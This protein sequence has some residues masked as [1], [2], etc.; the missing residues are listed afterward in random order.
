MPKS[1]N[2]STICQML[3]RTLILLIILFAFGLRLYN[4][5]YHSLWFDEAVSVY[6]AKQDVSRIIEVGFTLD[7]DRLPPLYYLTL[8]SWTF[9]FGWHEFTVR[10]LSVFIGTLLVPVVMRLTR[11]LF[12]QP[13]ALISGLLVALN[14]F[15]IWYSQE[16]RMYAPAVLFGTWAVLSWLNMVNSHIF[17]TPISQRNRG[18]RSRRTLILHSSFFIFFSILALYSHLYAGFLLPALGLWLLI[19]Y[20]RHLKLIALFSLAGFIITLAYSPILLAIW[21]FSAEATPG[22]PLSGLLERAWWL[23]HAFTVWQ[24]PLSSRL[25]ML[26]PAGVALFALMSLAWQTPPQFSARGKAVKLAESLPPPNLPL[27]EE[28]VASLAGRTEGDRDSAREAA[29]IKNP[30]LLITMLLA[31]PFL[32]AN[33]LLTRNYLAFFGER[34]FIVMVPW[35]LIL[36]TLGADTLGRRLNRIMTNRFGMQGLLCRL[37]PAWASHDIIYLTPIISLLSLTMLALPGQWSVPANKEAWRQSVEYLADHSAPNHGILIHPDWV[38]YPFQFYFEG[39]GQTYAAFSDVDT[40]T[41]LDGP[42]EGVVSDHPVIWLIQSHHD[43]PDPN[44][45]VE[46]WFAVRYPLV[47]EL[48]PPGITLKGYAPGYQMSDLPS[49]AN[50]LDI[51]FDDGLHLVGY[52][53]D[54]TTRAIDEL[55]HPP[56]GWLHVTLYWSVTDEPIPTDETPFVHLVGPEGVW[57]VSLDRATDALKLYPTSHWQID[58][59]IRHDLD[60]NLNPATPAGQY[61]LVVGLGEELY[62]IG[63]T[64]VR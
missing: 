35:L 36:T 27:L 56:S 59:I 55:F 7:E 5:T 42:L 33:L 28:G 58:Q 31:M 8:K 25:N 26:I 50:P 19:S 1:P 37:N 46:Q 13:V 2:H 3:A 4:L 15:L 48:Y 47:T 39:P 41:N 21:R 16:A 51:Q 22:N 30:R 43:G 62:S 40:T 64:T 54:E 49:E 63:E 12:N 57:G 61:Q 45:L 24:A 38:R 18:S 29:T 44:R 23:F 60:V 32:I 11:T 20:P 17:R 34:Y 14:P 52:H 6:W 10:L 53:A 9:L